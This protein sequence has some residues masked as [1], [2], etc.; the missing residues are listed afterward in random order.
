MDYNYFMLCGT[1][2]LTC[3]I[4][5]LVGAVEGL[6]I[7][8]KDRHTVLVK[9]LQ[10]LSQNFSNRDVPS[11]FITDVHR[12][13]KKITGIDVPFAE[14]RA[15][16]N[17]IGLKIAERIEKSLI[18]MK[19]E[20]KKLEKLLKWCVAGNHLDFRTAGKGYGFSINKAISELRRIA[21][22]KF[23]V[24]ESR[25]IFKTIMS[26]EKILYIHDNVGEIAIDKLLIKFLREHNKRVISVL[27]G[28]PI[29]SDATISD[30]TAVGIDRVADRIIMAGPDTLGISWEEM[31]DELRDELNSADIIISKGQANFYVLSEH[32]HELP[33]VVFLLTTKCDYVSQSFGFF[34]K[35]SVIKLH[36]KKN[37]SHKHPFILK[38]PA[39]DFQH[40]K[41][42][43]RN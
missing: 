34:G 36:S 24:N 35:G 9:S 15:D 22:G 18:R 32:L 5:D 17:R 6:K 1:K 33:S 10:Y 26:S 11:R 40:F 29:T 2:C 23:Q 4:D 37:Q 41:Q 38:G 42:Q 43:R 21:E 20:E 28:G 19:S 13:L 3:I 14:L 25:R 30:G 7:Q 8:E 31:S 39:S 27:R 12:I 16:C